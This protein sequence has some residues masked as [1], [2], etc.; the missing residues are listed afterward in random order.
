MLEFAAWAAAL[1]VPVAALAFVALRRKR[2]V[3]Y[4]HGLLPS[5][6]ASRRSGPLFRRLKAGYD[7]AL[8]TA[9]ALAASAYLALALVGFRAPDLSAIEETGTGRAAWIIDCSASMR[10]GWPGAR[11]I[12]AAARE[13]FEAS[14]SGSLAALYLLSTERGSA[15]PI[16]KRA[17]PIIERASTPEAFTA[18]LESSEPFLGVDYA[19]LSGSKLRHYTSVVLVCDELGP[20]ARGFTVMELGWREPRALVPAAIRLASGPWAGGWGRASFIASGTAAP[21]SLS[22]M[23]TDGIWRRPPPEA[24]RIE[25]DSELVRVYLR[26]PGRYRLS[27][28]SG[29]VEFELAGLKAPERPRARIAPQADDGSSP[30]ER[31]RLVVADTIARSSAGRAAA[32]ITAPI[33]AAIAESGGRGRRGFLS[34]SRAA[35]GYDGLV[36]EPGMARGALVAAGWDARADLS[37]GE[38]ALADGDAALAVWTAWEARALGADRGSAAPSM[39]ADGMAEIGAAELAAIPPEEWRRPTPGGVILGPAAER[40]IVA[41][42]IIKLALIIALAA[43]YLTKLAIRRRSAGR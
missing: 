24:W 41:A 17:D 32:P 36:I 26:D 30:A 15:T 11:P 23:G 31:A 3:V 14:R 34:L 40:R 16:L 28:D 27:W 19:L 25:P 13:A 6:R 38:A 18:A 39:R 10:W 4:P 9:A 5:S 7:T 35:A 42:E 21:D 12:D 20:E 1:L 37:L 8:D 43:L 33:T 2:R 22:V 29:A